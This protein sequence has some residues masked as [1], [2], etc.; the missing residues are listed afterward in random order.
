MRSLAILFFLGLISFPGTSVDIPTKTDLDEAMQAYRDSAALLHKADS[1]LHARRAYFIARQIF[2]E[3]PS[4]L[5]PIAHVY[6]KAAARYQEPIA[7][8]QYQQVLDL[9]VEA[10]GNESSELVPVLVDAAEEA[11]HRREPE[12]AY[13][14][15]K[16]A[17]EILEREKDTE[18][19]EMARTHMGLARLYLESGEI[20]RAETRTERALQLALPHMEKQD[21]PETAQLYFWHAQVMR[22]AGNHQ[23]AEPSYKKALS[24]YLDKEPMARPVLSI[25]RHLIEVSHNLNKPEKAVHH[26]IESEIY[27]NKRNMGHWYPIYDP[28]GRLTQFDKAKTGQILA[29]FT[30]TKDCR[31]TDIIIHKTLGISAE[32][33]TALLQQAYFVPRMKDGRIIADQRVDQININVY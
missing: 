26:C 30:R 12:M 29:G 11:I 6:A 17:S 18:S 28:A 16:T 31:A 9:V 21:Y 24:L 5:A 3:N 2:T 22:R 27:E 25:H 23:L 33:A 15:L 32:E 8:S 19:F 14:W 7:L 13:G 10:H 1:F 4:E 20:H